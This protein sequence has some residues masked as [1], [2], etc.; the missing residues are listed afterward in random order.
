[1]L[2]QFFHERL[3]HT[4]RPMM[5]YSNPSLL[6][7]H[8]NNRHR[9]HSAANCLYK[10]VSKSHYMTCTAVIFGH[11][12]KPAS[13]FLCQPKHISGIRATEFIN[14]LIIIP[15]CYYTHFFVMMHQ[16]PHQ[17]MFFGSHILC[18]VNH[19]H[20]LTNPIRFNLALFNHFRSLPHYILHLIQ[21]AYQSQ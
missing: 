4:G 14:I 18:L 10:L 20:R 16:G 5:S 13:R 11:F 2:K 12:H 21:I 3:I 7:P 17:C 15:H 9:F 8:R 6:L 19:Q 1:M